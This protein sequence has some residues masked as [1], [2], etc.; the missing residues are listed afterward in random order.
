MYAVDVGYGQLAWKLR[1]DSRVVL[2][3][4]TNIRHMAPEIIPE[5]IELITIDVSFISLKIILP[6]IKRHL[7]AR[8]AIL[9][10]IKP[11]FEVGRGSV[12]K[13]GIVKDPLLHE[14]VVMDL[15]RFF[16][17]Q[18]FETAGVTPSPI[19]GTKGNIEFLV[20]MHNKMSN[21]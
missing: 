19:R 5:K 17:D 12:G 2:I 9:A 11:Q 10:L 4:R 13:G 3:E 15:T 1:K 14:Q 18:G 8:G 7:T 21:D 16:H 6:V 20:Y